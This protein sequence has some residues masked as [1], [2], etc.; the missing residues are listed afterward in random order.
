MEFDPFNS[1][2]PVPSPCL[3]V[4]VMDPADGQCK[5][6]QRNIDEIIAWGTASDAYKRKVW[7]RINAIRLHH[8]T[9]PATS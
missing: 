3:Q 1:P 6:C 8:A 2:G 7:Q 4:C 5:G 9:L